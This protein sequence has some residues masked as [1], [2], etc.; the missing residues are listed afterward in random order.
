MYFLSPRRIHGDLIQMFKLVNNVEIVNFSKGLNYS[1]KT[2]DLKVK[3]IILEE[4]HRTWFEKE[5]GIVVR[6]LII[7]K[8][9]C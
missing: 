1:I 7:F 6:D 9:N 5:L 4:T 2:Q 8:Q 3:C